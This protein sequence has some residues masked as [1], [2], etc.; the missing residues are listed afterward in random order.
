VTGVESCA[1][2]YTVDYR[3]CMQRCSA[4]SGTPINTTVDRCS[5]IADKCSCAAT[6]GACGWCSSSVVIDGRTIERGRCMQVA[7]N[8]ACINEGY[9]FATAISSCPA[10][11]DPRPLPAPIVESNPRNEEVAQCVN[12]ARCF[13]PIRATQ[14]IEATRTAS[15]APAVLRNYI[16]VVT[17]VINSN[18]E[19]GDLSVAVD[20]IGQGSPSDAER[21]EICR[22][23]QRN[24]FTALR[25]DESRFRT[26]R[27]ISAATTKRQAATSGSITTSHVVDITMDNRQSSASSVVLAFSALIAAVVA[28]F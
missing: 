13:D 1:F 22:I 10:T 14:S 28:F 5:F 18:V 6:N 12:D 2:Q 24:I 23:V 20:T 7:S 8:A 19:R 21:A 9:T 3:M 15:D 17:L 26:C 11:S 16:I 4:A 25:V 27:M